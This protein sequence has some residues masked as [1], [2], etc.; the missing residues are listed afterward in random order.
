MHLEVSFAFESFM[1]NGSSDMV[2]VCVLRVS[3]QV[4]EESWGLL[5]GKVS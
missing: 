4:P 5:M 3:F 2:A 1:V